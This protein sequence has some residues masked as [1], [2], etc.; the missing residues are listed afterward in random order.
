MSERDDE[1]LAAAV[2]LA[3]QLPDDGD[4][5][6]PPRTRRRKPPRKRPA[7]AAKPAGDKAPRTSRPRATSLGKRVQDLHATIG[8]GMSMAPAPWAMPTGQ[9]LVEQ[10]AD[11]GKAWEAVAKEN[12]RVAEA[13]ERVLTVSTV[14]QLLG[15]YVPV[16]LVALQS[17]GKLPEQLGGT[18][19]APAPDVPEPAPAPDNVRPPTFPGGGF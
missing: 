4:T 18:P 7:R 8:L 9:A 15:A 6:A 14:G 11:I 16:V 10:S 1:A 2:E 13:L 5:T 19:A 3:E 12:P 17:T